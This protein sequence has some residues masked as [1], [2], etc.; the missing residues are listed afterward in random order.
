MVEEEFSSRDDLA[1]DPN[2]FKVELYLP[3][4]MKVN[5]LIR[6]H[7]YNPV[8]IAE[9][10]LDFEKSSVSAFVVDS[11][12]ES[13]CAVF[14]ELIEKVH[15]QRSILNDVSINKRLE[16]L[17]LVDSKSEINKVEAEL[18][19]SRMDCKALEKSLQDYGTVH[20]M[21]S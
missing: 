13:L 6:F 21:T 16:N 10:D 14:M 12:A 11:W 2:S 8:N 20:A 9:M 17:S 4:C 1:K 5:D 3:N 18:R 7:G 15:S 19:K